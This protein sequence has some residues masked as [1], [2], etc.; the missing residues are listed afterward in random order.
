VA[1]LYERHV[2]G[3]LRAITAEQR[4]CIELTYFDGLD[5]IEVAARRR[6]SPGAVDD[7]LS[8]GLSAMLYYLR[9]CARREADAAR[10]AAADFGPMVTA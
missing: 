9:A 4:A 2:V 6:M 7:A 5:G 1:E 10:A 8:D 3:A